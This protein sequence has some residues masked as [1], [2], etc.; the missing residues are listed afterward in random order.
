MQ[1]NFKPKPKQT[2]NMCGPG[3]QTW[4]FT[5]D[6][7]VY[8]LIYMGCSQRKKSVW[9]WSLW[10]DTV[11]QLDSLGSRC[12]D[13]EM[14]LYM[15]DKSERNCNQQREPMDLTKFWPTQQGALEQRLSM[16]LST[17]LSRN[18]LTLVH[19]SYSHFG[20]GCPRRDCSLIKS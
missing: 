3:G 7:N 8:E 14:Q 19:S 10:P 5:W 1:W 9:F 6:I 11:Y 4:A 2:F 17:L 13:A 18:V 20:W 16:R 15:S 12:W